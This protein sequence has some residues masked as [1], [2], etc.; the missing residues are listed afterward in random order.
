MSHLMRD[1]RPVT[2]ELTL[3]LDRAR[4]QSPQYWLNLQ[5]AFDLKVAQIAIKSNL[6]ALRPMAV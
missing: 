5:I 2:A 4:G 3:R 6:R 1:E